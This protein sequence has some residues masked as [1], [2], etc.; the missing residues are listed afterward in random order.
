MTYRGIYRDGFVIIQGNVDLQNGDSVDVNLRGAAKAPSRSKPR[1]TPADTK[2]FK[3][4]QIAEM[5]RSNAWDLMRRTRMTK[6][7][8]IAAVLDSRATWKDRPDWK[9]KSTAEI[10]SE[11]RIRA[12]RRGR[13]G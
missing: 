10:A 2:A 4:G 7:H 11:L 1:T 9:G 13:D 6:A 8:R 3:R 12:S 5:S